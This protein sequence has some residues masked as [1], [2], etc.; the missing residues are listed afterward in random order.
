MAM[1][2]LLSR[3][4][5]FLSAIRSS[6]PKKMKK[7]GSDLYATKR[8]SDRQIKPSRHRVR[9]AEERKLCRDLNRLRFISSTS[10]IF[11]PGEWWE[12]YFA[13]GLYEILRFVGPS[14]DLLAPSKRLE[15]AGVHAEIIKSIAN[16]E[17]ELAVSDGK[18]LGTQSFLIRWKRE[19]SMKVR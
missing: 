19:D 10:T 14:R 2:S 16:L 3:S 4:F 13:F 12:R 5:A 17:I 8:G 9:R 1:I 15:S 11:W 7:W 6:Q 18:V